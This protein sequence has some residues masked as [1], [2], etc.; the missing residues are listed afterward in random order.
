MPLQSMFFPEFPSQASLLFFPHGIRVL[1]AWLLG[2]RAIPALLPGVF[3]VF[4]YVGGADVF[5]PSRLAA[6][7]IAVA[8]APALFMLLAM[9][10]Q[11]VRPQPGKTPCWPCVMGVGIVTS[12]LTSL[13]TNMAFGSEMVEYVAYLIGDICGLFFLMLGLLFSFRY[14]RFR[15]T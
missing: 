3:L 7:A 8:V 11:D 9:V 4:L 6:I 12:V 2:W 14:M 5:M 15:Q 13:L 1:T 10:R